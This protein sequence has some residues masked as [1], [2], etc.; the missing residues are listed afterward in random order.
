MTF[1]EKNSL[2]QRV[3]IPKH[4]AFVGGIAMSG[5]EVVQV[6]F[7]HPNSLLKLFDVLSPALTKRSLCLPV[8]LLALL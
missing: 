3:L 4:Q 8:A 5:L 7:V 6:G 2:K 1:L